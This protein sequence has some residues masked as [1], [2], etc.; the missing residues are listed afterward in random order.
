LFEADEPDHLED[1]SSF[2][3][4][5]LAALLKHSSQLH[6][7]MGIAKADAVEDDG[8]TEVREFKLRV[9]DRLA[10]SGREAGFAAAEAFKHI[11]RL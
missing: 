2:V 5:K 1:V 9:T 8:D 3:D 11:D 6:S 10:E 7:T 4:R